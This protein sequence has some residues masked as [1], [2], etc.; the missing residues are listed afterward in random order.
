MERALVTFREIKVGDVVIEKD[1]SWLVT[2]VIEIIKSPVKN[3]VT[4]FEGEEIS[5]E[6]AREIKINQII[7]KAEFV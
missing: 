1:G 7:W 4:L 3:T 6:M 5:H 2:K